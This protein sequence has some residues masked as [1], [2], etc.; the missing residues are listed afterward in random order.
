VE[1]KS[2][3]PPYTTVREPLAAVPQWQTGRPPAGPGLGLALAGP[4]PFGPGPCPDRP[5]QAQ[6]RSGVAR[7]PNSMLHE[8]NIL[9]QTPSSLSDKQSSSASSIYYVKCVLAPHRAKLNA[10]ACRAGSAGLVVC[11]S[12]CLLGASSGCYLWQLPPTCSTKATTGWSHPIATTHASCPRCW[13]CDHLH[14]YQVLH[15]NSPVALLQTWHGNNKLHQ[16]DSLSN[17]V[18]IGISNHSRDT[19]DPAYPHPKQQEPITAHESRITRVYLVWRRMSWLHS[20][21]ERAA[22]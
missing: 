4:G 18:C 2:A 22:E 1:E 16:H 14:R 7:S 9:V 10:N 21:L 13:S 15:K 19:A 3:K 6:A 12:L 11:T 20:S 5:G 8:T 17:S